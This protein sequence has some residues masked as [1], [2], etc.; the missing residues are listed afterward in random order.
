MTE[1]EYHNNR[2]GKPTPCHQG[3]VKAVTA[4][5]AAVLTYGRRSYWYLPPDARLAVD[6][7][8]ALRPNIWVIA[9]QHRYA[10]A[11]LGS[12]KALSLA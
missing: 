11:A 9:G 3:N 10:F 12:D 8:E 2:A 6:S 5:S 4:Q 7:P 1:M